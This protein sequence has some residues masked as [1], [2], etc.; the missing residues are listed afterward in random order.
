[1]LTVLCVDPLSRPWQCDMGNRGTIWSR[2][3]R[4]RRCVAFLFFIYF[5]LLVYFFRFFVFYF[6]FF[7]SDGEPPSSMCP[8]PLH[9]DAPSLNAMTT[10]PPPPQR[11]YVALFFLFFSSCLTETP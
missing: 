2:T 6:L 11:R 5:F 8:S 1:M 7:M 9:A 10:P 3:M 4:Q